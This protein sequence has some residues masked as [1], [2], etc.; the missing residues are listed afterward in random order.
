MG[1]ER[2]NGKGNGKEQ[3]RTA[4]ISIIRQGPCDEA[5]KLSGGSGGPCLGVNLNLR[6]VAAHADIHRAVG[7]SGQRMA[8]GCR[9]A[10]SFQRPVGASKLSPVEAWRSSRF[11][12]WLGCLVEL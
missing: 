10:L 9:L 3:L 8:N 7:D 1:C 4:T 2:L 11:A 5:Q 6:F 12:V